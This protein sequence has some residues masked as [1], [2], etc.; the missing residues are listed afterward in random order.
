MKYSVLKLITVIENVT[1]GASE[2]GVAIFQCSNQNRHF[3]FSSTSLTFRFASTLF[4]S[5]RTVVFWAFVSIT[6]KFSFISVLVH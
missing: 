3:L 2:K 4:A 1:V 5:L 6:G